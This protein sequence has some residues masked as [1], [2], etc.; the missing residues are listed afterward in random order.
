MHL[1]GGKHTRLQ[2]NAN[3]VNR[4]FAMA[5]WAVRRH[6]DYVARFEF[7][8][9]TPDEGLN[10]D[11]KVL[12]EIQSKPLEFDAG[13]RSDVKSSFDWPRPDDC[14]TVIPHTADQQWHSAGYRGRSHRQPPS[15]KIDPDSSH[16]WIDGVESMVPC[17]TSLLDHGR[18]RG[19][20]GYV[21]RKNVAAA[22]LIH[23]GFFTR[24][25]RPN[26]RVAS[27]RS[28]LH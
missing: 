18:Q 9:T 14:S 13:G 2:A 8:A 28:S 4:N 12:M 25:T 7:Q 10:R 26:R 27:V 20:V 1:R 16:E 22:N 23:H 5:A 6:L 19:G 21:Y 11:L 3:D 24:A 15:D 17:R